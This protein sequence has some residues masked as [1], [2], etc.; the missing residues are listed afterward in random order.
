[1]LGWF[2]LYNKMDQP[3]IYISLICAQLCTTH[4]DPVE[5]RPP[6]SSLS[7]GFS[8]REYWS[9]SPFPSPGDLPNPGIEPEAPAVAEGFFTTSATWEALIQMSPHFWTSFSFRSP[10]SGVKWNETGSLVLPTFKLCPHGIVQHMLSGVWLFSLN[11]MFNQL[12][13]S[14]VHVAAV[15]CPF[16]S[17]ATVYFSVLFFRY[18]LAFGWISGLGSYEHIFWWKQRA[19]LCWAWTEKWS[20]PSLLWKCI[21]PSFSYTRPLLIFAPLLMS[22]LSYCN[23]FWF[24]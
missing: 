20:L 7:M 24:K 18:W 23:T 16:V 14:L 2:L 9:G 17:Y 13:K 6:G 4:C 12:L 5:C 1:M 15:E 22:L 21:F 3:C 19:F 8:R 11:I 10:Q